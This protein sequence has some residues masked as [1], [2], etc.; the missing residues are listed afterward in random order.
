MLVAIAALN[1]WDIEQMDAIAA[2]LNNDLAE[3]IYIELPEGFAHSHG[4][5]KV[6]KLHKSLYVLEQS[7]RI[8]SDNVCQF[9]VSI[10]FKISPANACVYVCQSESNFIAVYVH[11]DDMAITGTEMQSIQRLITKNLAMDDLGISHCVVGVQI[12]PTRP[13]TYAI[14]QP[15]MIRSILARFGMTD[16][17]PASTPPSCGSQTVSRY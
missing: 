15:F 6:D 7:A 11:V 13:T 4:P 3:E 17:C 10:G 5:G 2:F 8:W 12:T 14:G 16:F 1:G 9:L